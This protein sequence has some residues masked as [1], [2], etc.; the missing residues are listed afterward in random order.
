MSSSLAKAS[1]LGGSRRPGLR[2]LFGRAAALRSPQAPYPGLNQT[3]RSCFFSPRHD[4]PQSFPKDCPAQPSANPLPT[5]SLGLPQNHSAGGT[6]DL[7]RGCSSDRFAASGPRSGERMC[8]KHSRG[9]DTVPSGNPLERSTRWIPLGSRK[10]TGSLG[11]RGSMAAPKRAAIKKG[12]ISQQ[13][14]TQGR[15]APKP[16]P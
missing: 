10:E 14:T 3:N 9:N 12:I 6:T 8:R 4:T 13:R 7:S 16:Q 11:R 5:T 15:R 2:I 1:L